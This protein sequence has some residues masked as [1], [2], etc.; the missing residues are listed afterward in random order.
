MKKL[1]FIFVFVKIITAVRENADIIAAP[2]QS[3]ETLVTWNGVS[4]PGSADRVNTALPAKSDIWGAA[5]K[6][7]SSNTA[8]SMNISFIVVDD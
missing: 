4:G 5:I 1:M 3:V 2:F 7:G 6:G 8:V